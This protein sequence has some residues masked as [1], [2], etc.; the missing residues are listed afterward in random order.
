M[1]AHAESILLCLG[2]M[3]LMRSS[4]LLTLAV[5]L[6]LLA[7]L[8]VAAVVGMRWFHANRERLA[9]WVTL[10]WQRIAKSP[11]FAAV[12]ARH[13]RAWA[14]VVARLARGEYLG[15]HL[16]V[17]II[18]SLAA[19]WLFGGV[20]E[21][22]IHHDPLTAVDLQLAS[23]FRRHA[24]PL[25][26]SV[27]VFF[28]TIGSP[29]GMAVL[30]ITVAIVLVYRRCWISLAAWAAAFAGAGVLAY[31]IKV[32]IHRPRPDGATRFL[33]GASFSFPSGHALGSL[34][35]FGMLAYLLV[36]SWP[37]A[38]RH[39]VMVSI[40]AAMLVLAIGIARLY[41]VV[42]YLSDVIAGFAAGMV[43]LAACITAVEIALRQRGRDTS[44]VGLE[45]PRTARPS[46]G[47]TTQARE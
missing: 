25:G 34:V 14:F 42:H 26:D 30:A 8:A 15:L 24:T 1:R 23:W 29:M 45:R 33:R 41:L 27:G 3:P 35:G 39:R 22:V 38:R 21:D 18:V 13:P 32:I 17:G 44:S 20:T 12:R 46:S 9:R 36:S 16:T 7:T 11:R 28:S 31:A 37:P 40:G 2:G 43:W 6:S 10:G 19:L 4:E 47:P 5:S